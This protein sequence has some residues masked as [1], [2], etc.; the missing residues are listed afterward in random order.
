MKIPR[1]TL[2]EDVY[3]W[4]ELEVG[5]VIVIDEAHYY[6]PKR[7]GSKNV[8]PE[9]VFRMTELRK[10]NFDVFL[11]TQHPM[12]VDVFVRRLCN[13]HVHYH[14]AFISTARMFRIRSNRS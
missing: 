14:R 11:I 8:E 5:S 4:Y 9:H 6:F 7:S 3:K 13:R 2:I 1:W 10:P 12:N